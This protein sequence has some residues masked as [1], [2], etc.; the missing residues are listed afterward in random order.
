MSESIIKYFVFLNN[1]CMASLFLVI[2]SKLITSIFAS[3]LCEIIYIII[4]VAVGTLLSG[5]LQMPL[6]EFAMYMLNTFLIIIV[7]CS[8]YNFV[9]IICSE[10]TV[11]TIICMG[12]FIAMFVTDMTVGYIAN[13][14]KYITH[15]YWENDIQY[16][17]NQE[18]DPNYPGD[19]KV[20]FAQTIELLM[21][22]GQ[23]SHISNTNYSYKMP[24]YSISEIL[25]FNIAGIYLFSKKELK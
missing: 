9:A 4:V 12:I 13:S 18:P 22:Q 3:I 14:S 24:I 7:Y 2:S 16:I 10:I 19:E 5:R 1:S 15:S 6:G 25:V 8:I 20:K 11:S 17:I 21:P 23:A